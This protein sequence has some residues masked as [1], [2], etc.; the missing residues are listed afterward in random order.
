M[1][2]IQKLQKAVRD[3][4]FRASPSNGN[5]SSPCTVDDL[6]KLIREISK[7]LSAFINELDKS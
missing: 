2:D 4:E 3:F 6:N 1:A 5:G 7:V